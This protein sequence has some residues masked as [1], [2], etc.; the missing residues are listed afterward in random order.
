MSHNLIHVISDC[1][2]MQDFEIRSG[3]SN[4]KFR[5]TTQSSAVLTFNNFL[6]SIQVNIYI[7]IFFFN[8]RQPLVG[9]DILFIETSISH[10]DTPH[11]VGLLWMSDQPDA[12]TST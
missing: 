10:A 5:F 4:S 6:Q 3:I 12:E 9:Q 7:Y 2:V 1:N 8:T 11:S